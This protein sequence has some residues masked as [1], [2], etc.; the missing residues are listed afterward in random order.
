MIRFIFHDFSL[1][2]Y[3][4]TRWSDV[5]KKF[6]SDSRYKNVDSSG[7]REDYFMDFVHDLKEES[8]KHKK[9]DKK[10]SRSRDRSRSRSRK[11]SRSRSPKKKSKKEKRDRSKDRYDDEDS[12]KDKKKSKKD[13]VWIYKY[14]IYNTRSIK[15]Y[16]IFFIF[17]TMKERKAK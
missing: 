15:R 10:R 2:F 7:L 5:K 16:Y 9:K 1:L 8:R 14:M 3:R 6:D 12:R 11:R 4:H 13:K 17:R